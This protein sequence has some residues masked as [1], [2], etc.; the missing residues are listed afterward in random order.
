MAI[1]PIPNTNSL[2]FELTDAPIKINPND[3]KI[4][5]FSIKSN[6]FKMFFIIN[7]ALFIFLI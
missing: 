5:Q 1:L 4:I 7:N 6:G 3:P 2:A